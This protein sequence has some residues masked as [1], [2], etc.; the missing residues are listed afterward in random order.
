MKTT[1]DSPSSMMSLKY[2]AAWTMALSLAS[3]GDSMSSL[4][5]SIMSSDVYSC[6]DRM[7]AMINHN[8]PEYRCMIRG[9]VRIED[10]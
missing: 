7:V 10:E 1:L 6:F 3:L 8:T 9:F 2:L 4:Y 5:R